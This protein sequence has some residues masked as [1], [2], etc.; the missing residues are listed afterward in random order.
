MIGNVGE[1]IR[2]GCWF[3]VADSFF[4][5]GGCFCDGVEGGDDGVRLGAVGV[6]VVIL[7]VLTAVVHEKT[8]E[9]TS[10]REKNG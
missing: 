9:W 7:L 4:S 3:Y 5:F 1:S 10:W 8:T 2:A 6:G